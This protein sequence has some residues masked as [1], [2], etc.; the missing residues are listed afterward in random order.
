MPEA[1]VSDTTVSRCLN[2][3]LCYVKTDHYKK[4]M[5]NNLQQSLG[6]AKDKLK[7]G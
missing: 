5:E 7:R 2:G 1:G 4:E 3:S 6:R